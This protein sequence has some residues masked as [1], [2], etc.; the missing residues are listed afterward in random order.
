MKS[1]SVIMYTIFVI[2]SLAFV[3]V[4][5]YAAPGAI[6]GTLTCLKEEHADLSLMHGVV[7]WETCAVRRMYDY[8]ALGFKGDKIPSKTITLVHKL[9]HQPPGSSGAAGFLVTKPLRDLPHKQVAEW[10]ASELVFFKRMPQIDSFKQYQAKRQEYRD[11]VA[12]HG[13]DE[14][15]KTKQKKANLASGFAQA[16]R[17]LLTAFDTST[18]HPP[19]ESPLKELA[20][21]P[22]KAF[23]ECAD[24]EYMPVTVPQTIL[25]AL[26]Y[27]KTE[28]DRAAFRTYY[29]W[30]DGRLGCLANPLPAT[31]EQD[32]FS[33]DQREQL[34][35]ETK[36]LPA[37]QAYERWV[38][39]NLSPTDYPPLVSYGDVTVQGG[40]FTDCMENTLRNLS[41]FLAYN[42]QT[43]LFDTA[44]LERRLG[45]QV[46][47][48]VR[49]FYD[50]HAD[51]TIAAQ[52]GAH[53]AWAEVTTALPNHIYCR[54]LPPISHQKKDCLLVTTQTQAVT[55]M[56]TKKGYVALPSTSV[57]YDMRPLLRNFM[58]SC[59]YLF[60]LQLFKDL[61]VD[62]WA[63]E[64]FV[65]EHL[66]RVIKALK[67]RVPA[68]LDYGFLEQH[69]G[70]ETD[71]FVPLSFS[72]SEIKPHV[73]SSEEKPYAFML[74]LH[75]AYDDGEILFNQPLTTTSAL[76]PLATTRSDSQLELACALLGDSRFL[77]VS[78]NEIQNSNAQEVLAWLFT[79]DLS[80][81]VQ[82][83]ALV[84]QVPVLDEHSLEVLLFSARTHAAGDE[85]A[86]Q[87]CRIYQ[88]ALSRGLAD[89]KQIVNDAVAVACEAV[90]SKNMC[91]RGEA[92]KVFKIL[93]AHDKGVDAATTC[94]ASCTSS[95][96]RKETS[97]G[98][99]LFSVLV[100]QGKAREAADKAA[101]QVLQNPAWPMGLRF[102]ATHLAT[103]LM[104]H[105]DTTGVLD[106]TDSPD[107]TRPHEVLRS[108]ETL[109]YGNAHNVKKRELSMKKLA[110]LVSL[111]SLS[112]YASVNSVRG[113]Y[114]I[115]K[116]AFRD[117]SSIHGVVAWKT[118]FVNDLYETKDE[119]KKSATVK[120]VQKLFHKTVSSA[121]AA[122]LIVTKDIRHLDDDEKQTALFVA[123]MLLVLRELGSQQAFSEYKKFLA[124][125]KQLQI[126]DTK[127]F[128]I[129]GKTR[130]VRWLQEQVAVK[131]KELIAKVE[132]SAD[133][134]VFAGPL[135]KLVPAI[136]ESQLECVVDNVFSAE[137]VHLVLLA[138]LYKETGG[139]KRFVRSYYEQLH[140]RLHCLT[141]TLDTV[142]ETSQF[143]PRSI[144]SLI[145]TLRKEPLEGGFLENHFEEYVFVRFEQEV[146]LA[147]YHD[148]LF[149]G[150]EFTD[151]MDTAVRNMLNVITYNRDTKVF[152]VPLLEQRLGFKELGTNVRQELKSFYTQNSE[153][154]SVTDGVVHT[155][156][157]EIS[158]NI[159]FVAYNRALVKGVAEAL[160]A[161]KR[162][163]IKGV[164]DKGPDGVAEKEALASLF[165]ARGYVLVSDDAD[166]FTVKPTLK[167][168]IVML[169]YLLNLNLFNG[170]LHR[171]FLRDDFVAAYL[172]KLAKAVH[173]TVPTIVDADKRDFTD[174]LL[175]T[176]L[177]FN[178]T[179]PK[180]YTAAVTLLTESRHGLLDFCPVQPE[181]LPA[182]AVPLQE[183]YPLSAPL[184]VQQ[185]V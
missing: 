178:F 127:N 35:A 79:Q 181:Q 26:L 82:R 146:P 91:V 138:L 116:P 75:T 135:K 24:N 169:D 159:P 184:L 84:Q 122:D 40:G 157:A 41:N 185:G 182:L 45:T 77:L 33:T 168:L 155:S 106:M 148:A 156:W 78:S 164:V 47:E 23:L 21:Y 65:A 113:T 149:K 25:Q 16:Q 139:D 177:D 64:G 87:V 100:E 2:V 129:D 44:L 162:G 27:K 89:N 136:I 119:R 12:D 133:Y 167:N 72:F 20:H 59:D 18:E 10:V 19:Y 134:K 154:A 174:E 32:V 137:T 170:A 63:R 161:G 183:P 145:A 83:Y 132:S 68:T 180:P 70:T 105:R 142:W 103:Q 62:A 17:T 50:P 176:T 115:L 153:P 97:A 128:F 98:L 36:T 175:V 6:K 166:V 54:A 11:F 73:S 42:P 163:F 143:S 88:E 56:L 86:R 34:L 126:K 123:N 80:D 104:H 8:G 46:H 57:A 5:L 108:K 7:A 48:S 49:K 39:L 131:R 172:P 160:P 102:E 147:T 121:S 101:R 179:Q 130:G 31:W 51:P 90:R 61:P 4:D 125:Y 67:A 110:V 93:C 58:L 66:S 141:A 92:L 118:G 94:A 99:A 151:C 96:A 117:L 14:Q 95:S 53:D 81:N 74:T 85:Q 30:L 55:D 171:E 111:C 60:G 52:K 9:F 15:K 152:D 114:T 107:T 38:F 28:G 22:I 140:E 144:D 1:L 69:D 3:F 120:L 43:G 37:A 173:A 150:H 112:A 165:T 158:S 76:P 13:D 109:W 29:E 71:L 124:L